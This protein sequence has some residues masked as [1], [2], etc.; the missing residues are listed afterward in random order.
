MD[1]DEQPVQF[2]FCSRYLQLFKISS[3]QHGTEAHF[4]APTGLLKERIEVRRQ[5][6][7]PRRETS[8]KEIMLQSRTGIREST[9]GEENRVTDLLEDSLQNQFRPRSFLLGANRVQDHISVMAA[10]DR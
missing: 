6:D 2:S 4:L 9:K 1:F 3:P 8:R 7:I 5:N 10:D